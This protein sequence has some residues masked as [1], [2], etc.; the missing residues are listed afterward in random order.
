MALGLVLTLLALAAAVVGQARHDAEVAQRARYQDLVGSQFREQPD[1]HPHRVSHYGYLVFRPRAPL[2][3]FDSGVERF[4]GTSVFLEAHRQNSANF[5]DAAQGGSGERFGEL[6][7]ALVLQFLVPLFIFAVAGVSVTRER[8]DGTLALLLCQHASW[9]VLLGGKM[10]GSVLLVALLTL[11]GVVVASAWLATRAEV[12]WTGDFVARGVALL[13][14]HAL[15]WAACA[16]FAVSVSARQKTSRGA[17]VLLLSTWIALWVVLPRV[18]PAVSTALH[19]IPS[20]AAFDAAV[21]ARAREQGDSHDPNDPHFAQLRQETLARYGV[22]RVEELPLNYGGIVMQYGEK[23]T[24]DAYR[25]FAAQLLATYQRQARILEAA[26]T[27]SP[28]LA[29]RALSMTLAGSDLAHVAEFD[30]QAEAYRYALIQ[31]LNDLHINEVDQAR[32]RYTETA[33]GAPSRARIDRAFFERLPTFTYQPFTLAQAMKGRG[34]AVAGLLLS[35]ALI[36][37]LAVATMRRRPDA[38]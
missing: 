13:L 33:D 14:L 28:F 2:G 8:E 22:S 19:P 20:R 37:T 9:R 4:T 3:F 24:S 30:R 36:A 25:E 21:E 10:L 38:R 35:L 7:L 34:L 11:P 6:N 27:L 15:F 1:R 16:A 29:V 12:Q 18:L 31:S 23:A 26:G 32:D 17:L 5:S